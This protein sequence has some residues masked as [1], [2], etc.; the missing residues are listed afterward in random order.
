MYIRYVNEFKNMVIP[1]FN[2]FGNIPVGEYEPLLSEF[3]IRFVNDFVASTTRNTLYTNYINYN[4]FLSTFNLAEKEWVT[5]SFTSS[6]PDPNDVDLLLYI[7][8]IQ[9]IKTHEEYDFWTNLDPNVIHN[10]YQCHTHLILKYPEG[11]PRNE[12][13][14]HKREYFENLF[15]Q[16]RSD[17]P[18]GIIKFDLFSPQY[19]SDLKAEA[20][21]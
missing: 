9:L 18:R 7:D 20:G 5:G 19:I 21:V 10:T 17:R 15:Q 1:D 3:K 4:L 16:D 14:K 11:D 12:H 13:S 6:K 2:E 8:G